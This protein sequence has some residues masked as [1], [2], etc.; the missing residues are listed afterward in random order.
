MRKVLEK[1]KSAVLCLELRTGTG[2]VYTMHAVSPESEGFEPD[3]ATVEK[4]EWQLSLG[5]PPAVTSVEV[6]QPG[7]RLFWLVTAKF[8]EMEFVVSDPEK[9]GTPLL[10]SRKQAAAIAAEVLETFLG[11]DGDW[12]APGAWTTAP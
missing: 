7:N 11:G 10:F 3:V 2:T 12:A 9:L 8:A 1:S 5:R 4:E 6:E